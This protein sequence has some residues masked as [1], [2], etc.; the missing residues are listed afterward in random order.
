VRN[1]KLFNP[2]PFPPTTRGAASAVIGLPFLGE[3]Q[4]PTAPYLSAEYALSPP[5][6]YLATP[7]SFGL[8]PW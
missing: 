2:L 3:L 6:N 5:I 1:L 4:Q 7:I 8:P